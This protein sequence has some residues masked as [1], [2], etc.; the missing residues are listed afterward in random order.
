[1]KFRNPSNGYVET[2]GEIIWSPLVT[3]IFGPIYFAVKG[4]WG[5]FVIYVLLCIPV[6]TIL[7]VWIVAPFLAYSTVNNRYRRMGWIEV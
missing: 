3:L 1:M 2:A 5:A 4:C 6:V 7:V